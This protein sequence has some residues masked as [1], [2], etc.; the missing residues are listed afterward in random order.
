M[1]GV[2][3]VFPREGPGRCRGFRWE[4]TEEQGAQSPF[5]HDISF[6]LGT[7]FGAEA[8]HLYAVS[9]RTANAVVAARYAGACKRRLPTPVHG[10]RCRGL[11][12]CQLGQQKSWTQ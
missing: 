12:R 6:L 5:L 8:L 9:G 7:V 1:R 11:P 3:P 4:A 2:L 10:C